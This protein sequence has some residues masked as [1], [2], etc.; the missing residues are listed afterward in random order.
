MKIVGIMSRKRNFDF[1]QGDEEP[2]RGKNTKG[3][4]NM[5][6]VPGTSSWYIEIKFGYFIHVLTKRF[7]LKD[8]QMDF[9]QQIQY[10]NLHD[11]RRATI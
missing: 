3:N 8:M 9:T 4:N 11:Y 2:Q 1:L 7:Y 10:L 5:L 6:E